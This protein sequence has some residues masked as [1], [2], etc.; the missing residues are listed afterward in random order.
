MAKK[1]RERYNSV[2]TRSTYEK[3]EIDIVYRKRYRGV[4]SKHKYGKGESNT[5]GKHKE[6]ERQSCSRI[7]VSEERDTHPIRHSIGLSQVPV[8][9]IPQNFN[10]GFLAILEG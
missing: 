3:E 5:N 6:R 10:F 9:I 2:G 1:T 8:T 7:Y 4:V